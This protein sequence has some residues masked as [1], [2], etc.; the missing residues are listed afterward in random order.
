MWQHFL[1]I[2]CPPV[3]VVC[4]YVSDQQAIASGKD[5]KKFGQ[6]IFESVLLIE[7]NRSIECEYF[8]GTLSIFVREFNS[9]TTRR[10]NCAFLFSII[11]AMVKNEMK[12]DEK[13]K[14]RS[15]WTVHNHAI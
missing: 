13:S 15:G 11:G 1:E 10:N 3:S 7:V 2:L 4:G 5:E 12:D 14:R 9:E 6:F 8:V